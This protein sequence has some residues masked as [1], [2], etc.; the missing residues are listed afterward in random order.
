ML[1]VLHNPRDA[2]ASTYGR[3]TQRVLSGG[4]NSSRQL[5]RDQWTSF[6]PGAHP[7]Y[8]T[9]GQ[10]EAKHRPPGGQRRRAAATAPTLCQ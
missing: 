1:R 3:T 2:G 8:I 6:I 10:Y 9:L 5:P 4:K 7:G